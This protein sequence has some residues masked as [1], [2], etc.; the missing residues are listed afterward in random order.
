LLVLRFSRSPPVL[1]D[2]D[3]PHGPFGG[4]KKSGA[5]SGDSIWRVNDSDK[6]HG[7][8]GRIGRHHAGLGD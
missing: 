1:A 5:G 2:V 7:N 8:V 4:S 6:G 3:Q